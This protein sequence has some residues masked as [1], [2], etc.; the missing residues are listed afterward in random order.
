M[1][2]KKPTFTTQVF[3]DFAEQYIGICSSCLEEDHENQYEPG[4]RG[5]E[6]PNCGLKKAM[7]LEEALMMGVILIEEDEK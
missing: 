3:E 2:A 7:G 6:C 4:A 5:R 1:K